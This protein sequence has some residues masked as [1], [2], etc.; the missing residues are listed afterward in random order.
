MTVETEDPKIPQCSLPV[1]GPVMIA[2]V[3]FLKANISTIVGSLY[4]FWRFRAADS[5]IHDLSIWVSI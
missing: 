1:P 2:G 5:G 3:G 4:G